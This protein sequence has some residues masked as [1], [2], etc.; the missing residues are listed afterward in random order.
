MKNPLEK[1]TAPKLQHNIKVEKTRFRAKKGK[2][3]VDGLTKI[4]PS[5][6]FVDMLNATYD[7][8][9]AQSELTNESEYIFLNQ[10]N[11]PFYNHDIIGVI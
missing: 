4:M 7:A 1:V 11:M 5:N 8:L 10:S 9:M 6:R 2:D 3:I